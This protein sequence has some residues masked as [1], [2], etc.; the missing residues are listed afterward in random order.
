MGFR[1]FNLR[2]KVVAL[3][4]S[5]VALWA[6]AAWVTLGDGIN[7]LFAQTFDTK[8]LKPA[9]PLLA[10]LQSERRLSVA[11]LARPDAKLR[12][13]LDAQA[14]RTQR[15]VDDFDESVRH[16][17]IQ[18]AADDNLTRRLGD[19]QDRL[20]GLAAIRK[21]VRD[22]SVDRAGAT[23]A[24]SDVVDSMF[25]MYRALGQMEDEQIREDSVA[26][27]QLARVR[28]LMSQEDALFTGVLTAGNMTEKEYALFVRLVGAQR[29]LAAEAV[30]ELPAVDR[31]RYQR[32]L[33]SPGLIRLRSLED[34]VIQDG[35]RKRVPRIGLGDWR[36]VV[37]SALKEQH[38][39]ILTGSEELV[40][41]TTPV[42]AWVIIRLVLAAGLGLFAI[43]A[44]IVLSITTARHRSRQLERLRK[45]AWQLANE[46]LPDVVERLGNGEEVDVARQAPQLEFGDDDIGQVGKAFNAVQQTAIRT[47]VEQAELRRY[48]RELFLN[49]A[50]RNQALLHRLLTLMDAMERREQDAEKLEDLFRIDHLITRMR[51]NAEN[52]LV[53]SGSTPGR[54]WRR[55][56]PLI[57]VVRGAVAEVEDYTRVTVLPL[58]SVALVGRVVR[59]VIHLLAELIENALSFSP[60]NT[61]VVVR[62]HAVADGFLIEIE[63][64]GLGMSEEDR[65]VANARIVTDAKPN[66]ARINCLGL[67]VVSRLRARHGIHVEL[68]ESVYSG[69]LA[70]VL[71][72]TSLMAQA[73]EDTGDCTGSP[74]EAPSGIDSLTDTLTAG[75]ATS[76]TT[77]ATTGPVAVAALPSADEAIQLRPQGPVSDAAVAQADTKRSESAAL[78][79]RQRRKPSHPGLD[80]PTIPM[81]L[82]QPGD[83]KTTGPTRTK[84]PTGTSSTGSA[85][86]QRVRQAN[87]VPELRTEDPTIDL[88]R[89]EEIARP[90][91]QV[92]QMMSAYQSGT[93]RGRTDAARLLGAQPRAA[94]KPQIGEPNNE[95]PPGK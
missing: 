70:V 29:F 27:I 63:D 11:Y 22:A 46:R 79:T 4:T 31:V 53:L 55:D 86:P 6:F 82:C 34:R 74:T 9:D 32:I 92:R 5:M 64:R 61:P 39:L 89:P 51:R 60:P 40:E 93:R 67:Y 87:L 17:R 13:E 35:P 49:L 33:Q 90:P 12:A 52:L 95:E 19:V 23:E 62:G 47:A 48:V 81:A 65:A 42:S 1:N 44:A 10:E 57:D 84:T 16:W 2:S 8:I 18:W 7:L 58:G 25:R 80:E 3:L 85:L 56:V 50:R 68:K 76:G 14:Q 28:E 72:P 20:D 83:E 37:D 24:Y 38:N 54:T 88:A 30:S 45:A 75:L 71:I 59:D 15:R 43:I 41:R 77:P 21:A 73:Q 78:P 66:L 69:T 94:S 26:L 91:E 36:S